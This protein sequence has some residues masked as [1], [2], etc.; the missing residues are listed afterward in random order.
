VGNND[1]QS[2]SFNLGGYAGGWEY[3]LG[4]NLLN[5]APRVAE[6]AIMKLEAEVLTE[7]KNATCF[8][9]P[10]IWDSPCTNQ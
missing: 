8:W 3:V 2:R 7:E 9:I 1:S 6:E 10:F 4:L 5:E